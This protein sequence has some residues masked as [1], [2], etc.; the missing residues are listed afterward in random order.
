MGVQNIR[1]ATH[2]YFG[3]LGAGI[4]A[5]LKLRHDHGSRYV[6]AAFQEEIGFLGIESSPA[7]VRSPE[8]NGCAERLIGRLDL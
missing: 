7:F 4:A 5:G 2:E 8:G 3:G 1:E 6:S